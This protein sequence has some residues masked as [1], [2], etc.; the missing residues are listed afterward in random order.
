[1]TD[2]VGHGAFVVVERIGIS[3]PLLLV[4]VDVLLALFA[5]RNAS[6]FCGLSSRRSIVPKPSGHGKLFLGAA[7]DSSLIR[8]NAR[9]AQAFGH[10]PCQLYSKPSRLES[11]LFQSAQPR[12]RKAA[13]KPGAPAV[14]QT[15]EAQAI[16]T[17]RFQSWKSALQPPFFWTWIEALRLPSRSTRL[18]WPGNSEPEQQDLGTTEIT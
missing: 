13:P 4:R 11:F 1:M 12:N 10:V 6:R 7:V 3:L 2:L 5:P 14:T 16:P 15:G 17:G 18:L 9:Q 8:Q